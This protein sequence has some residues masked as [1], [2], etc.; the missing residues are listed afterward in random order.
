[1]LNIYISYF[2]LI[3]YLSIL[4]FKYLCKKSIIE[5]FEKFQELPKINIDDLRLLSK[6]AHSLV[7]GEPF[8][9]IPRLVAPNFFIGDFKITKNILSGWGEDFR[10]KWENIHNLEHV[11]RA[12]WEAY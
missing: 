9:V 11:P 6:I 4:I 7:K 12:D 3:I 2:L 5:K 1:M 8:K 10:K